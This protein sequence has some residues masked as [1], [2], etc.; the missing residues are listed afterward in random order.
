MSNINSNSF[1]RFLLVGGSATGLQYLIMAIL[2]YTT[3]MSP[4]LASGIGFI[5]SAIF[6]YWANARF[7]FGGHSTH[8][9]GIPR[10]LVTLGAGVAINAVVLYGLTRFRVPLVVSQLITTGVVLIWNYTIN[11]V[12]TFRK[13][14]A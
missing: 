8:R 12:W 6:N 14:P 4:V 7:T 5:I 10:F 11:A 13:R 2:I 1:L 3:A 9:Q